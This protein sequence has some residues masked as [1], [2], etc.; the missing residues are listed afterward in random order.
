MQAI[1]AKDFKEPYKYLYICSDK[2]FV[3]K[4]FEP[5]WKT[6]DALN[7]SW[8]AK[9][10]EKIFYDWTR[11]RILQVKRKIDDGEKRFHRGICDTYS[12]ADMRIHAHT[13]ACIH[14]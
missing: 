7:Y 2:S 11:L 9:A 10:D 5:A 8:K 1:V 12:Q 3:T 4:A 13:H 6:S 14:M